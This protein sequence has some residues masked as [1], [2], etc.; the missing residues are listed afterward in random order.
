MIALFLLGLCVLPLARLPM[1]AVQE[2]YKSAYRM[3]T[4]RLADLAFAQIKE[5]LYT[6]EI[7]WKELSKPKNDPQIILNDTHS[8]C[9]EPL[10]LKFNRSATLHSVGKKTKNGEEWRLVTCRIK[11]SLPNKGYKLFRTKKGV[12]PHRT[13][14]YQIV[15]Q[16]TN[17]STVTPEKTL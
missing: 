4:Q 2:E 12:A 5:K 16:K 3:Q 17:P 6:N 10:I 15:V 1:Q 7:S 8:A 9:F 11:I 14:I 13:Y